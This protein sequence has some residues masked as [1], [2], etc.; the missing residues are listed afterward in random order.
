MPKKKKH[1]KM[2]IPKVDIFDDFKN[3]VIDFKIFDRDTMTV[4][5]KAKNERADKALK[6]MFRNI[7][8]KNG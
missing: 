3:L 8:N 7:K 5:D 1:S 2:E 6:D 4:L